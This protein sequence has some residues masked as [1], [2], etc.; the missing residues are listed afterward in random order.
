MNCFV[1]YSIVVAVGSF[2]GFIE[3]SVFVVPGRLVGRPVVVGGFFGLIEYF[4]VVVPDGLVLELGLFR[5]IQSNHQQSHNGKN[6]HPLGHLQS[7]MSREC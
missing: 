5:F 7:E 1:N 3:Y 2:S 4:V 6:I